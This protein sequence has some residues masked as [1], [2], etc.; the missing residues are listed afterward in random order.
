MS[1]SRGSWEILF[2]WFHWDLL[3]CHVI[4]CRSGRH[5]LTS[6]LKWKRSLIIF[7]FILILYDKRTKKLRLKYEFLVESLANLHLVWGGNYR[8]LF[9]SY[10]IKTNLTTTYKSETVCH[11]RVWH[12]LLQVSYRALVHT[13]CVTTWRSLT[14]PESAASWHKSGICLR[15]EFRLPYG[16]G[17]FYGGLPWS[18]AVVECVP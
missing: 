7:S 2:W 16:Q 8:L 6:P 13:P 4:L 18:R 17:L 1:S 11:S 10:S 12:P 9:R 14:R 3:Y 15:H 5:I